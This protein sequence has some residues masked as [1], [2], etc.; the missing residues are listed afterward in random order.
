VNLYQPPVSARLLDDEGGSA[1]SSI[2]AIRRGLGGTS[3]QIP[4]SAGSAG[5]A[6]SWT[7]KVK[8]RPPGESMCLGEKVPVQQL[9]FGDPS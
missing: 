4:C 6:G 5:S 1:I 7:L 2:V 9:E 3:P 8:Q